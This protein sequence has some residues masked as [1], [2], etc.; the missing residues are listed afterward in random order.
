MSELGTTTFVGTKAA[1][2]QLDGLLRRP[3]MADAVEQ[4]RHEM[5]EDDCVYADNLA[6]IRRAAALTRTIW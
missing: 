1:Q 4:I 5:K 6:S 3:G 2:D